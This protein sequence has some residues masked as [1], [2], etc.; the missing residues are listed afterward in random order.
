VLRFREVGTPT[1][2]RR[3]VVG[4]DI[5]SVG[6]YWIEP[7][8]GAVL[9]TELVVADPT[10]RATID[11]VYGS[12]LLPGMLVPASMR[13]QYVNMTDRAVTTGTATYGS[14]RR[15]G[16]SVDEDIATPKGRNGQASRP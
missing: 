7:S 3:F 1:V 8:T 10:T 12:A 13:E 9:A 6:R 5:A 4:G 11:V 14:V 15:F 16:V 2:V